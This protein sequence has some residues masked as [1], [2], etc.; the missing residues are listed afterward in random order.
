VPGSVA[1]PF[2]VEN[3]ATAEELRGFLSRHKL[4]KPVIGQPFN[5]L[6]N[7]VVHGSR[8]IAGI[9][10]G[11]AGFLVERKFQGVTLT[12]RPVLLDEA[13]KARCIAFT[14]VMELFGHYHFE[15]LVDCVTGTNHFLEINHRFGGT[16][17]KVLVCGYQE[18]LYALQAQGVDV[19]ASSPT[20]TATVSS[21]K[22]LCKSALYALTNRLTPLDFPDESK[23]MRLWSTLKC[24]ILCRDEV[25]AWDDLTG[26]AAFYLGAFSKKV[27]RGFA[28][29]RRFLRPARSDYS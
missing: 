25:F 17:A 8:T 28:G 23:A 24:L 9:S 22:A 27:K 11:L 19:P 20:H 18:P 7:L 21:I 2:K 16:T 10:I 29:C 1:P 5:N 13:L 3:V 26:S 15:F 14:E 4:Q 6:P 12:L